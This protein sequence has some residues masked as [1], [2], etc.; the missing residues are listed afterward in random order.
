MK[1]PIQFI[2]SFILLAVATTSFAQFNYINPLPDSKNKNKQTTIILK[3]GGFIDASSLK[4]NLVSITGSKS[5]S[6]TSRIVL[7][8]DGKTICIY[9]QPIFQ[10]E[11]TV[12]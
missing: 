1:Q 4:N 8:D 11:E 6:H 9:P 12:S 2:F 3:N 7:A 5:G 10:G